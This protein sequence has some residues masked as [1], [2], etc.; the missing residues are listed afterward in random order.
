MAQ[1]SCHWP[2]PNITWLKDIPKH[3]EIAKPISLIHAFCTICMI[4]PILL[5]LMRP[6]PMHCYFKRRLLLDMIVN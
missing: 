3:S 4:Y 1:F 2:K 6:S 5:E